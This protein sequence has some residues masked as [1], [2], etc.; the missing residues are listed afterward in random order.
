MKA[1]PVYSIERI[2]KEED[3]E[4]SIRLSMSAK[5]L[6]KEQIERLAKE[7]S[8]EAIEYSKHAKRNTVM[9]EDILLAIDKKKTIF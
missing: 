7:I 2:F 1:I 6:L 3:K 9:R 5:R 4:D 8:K